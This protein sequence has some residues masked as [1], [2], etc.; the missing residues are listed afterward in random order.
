[1]FNGWALFALRIVIGV[2]LLTHGVSK[3]KKPKEAAFRFEKVGC[4]SGSLWARI[5]AIVEFIGA[6]FIIVGFLTQIFSLLV[7]I[8]LLAILLIVKRYAKFKGD[9][10][11]DLLMLA[12]LLIL[13]TSA[14]G[15]LSLDQGLHF[16][17]Y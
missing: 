14:G 9:V 8:Q 16:L 5:T 3:L 6:I 4:S 7:F 15:A 13:I 2:I 17:L 1:M 11:F 10:E 12:A